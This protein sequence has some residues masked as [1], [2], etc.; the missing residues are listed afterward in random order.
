MKHFWEFWA[1]LSCRDFFYEFRLPKFSYSRTLF[2]CKKTETTDEPFLRS[3]V[4]IGRMNEG[5]TEK[6]DG[7]SHIHRTLPLVRM[8]NK[9]IF[10]LHVFTSFLLYKKW[11]LT[12]TNPLTVNIPSNNKRLLSKP[13]FL[14]LKCNIWYAHGCI[15]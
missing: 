11:P 3:C 8:S 10:I 13:T 5:T 15:N 14:R 4:T 1:L 6:T 7:E 9:W 2:W 12:I